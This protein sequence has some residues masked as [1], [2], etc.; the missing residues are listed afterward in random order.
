MQISV[1]IE[2]R[3]CIS[4]HQ[5]PCAIVGER[6]LRANVILVLDFND[7]CHV[8]SSRSVLGRSAKTRCACRRRSHLNLTPASYKFQCSQ[9]HASSVESF[10]ERRS[11]EHL[12]FRP[13]QL[14]L[15]SGRADEYCRR[16]VRPSAFPAARRSRHE[17]TAFK[18]QYKDRA[19]TSLEIHTEAYMN[20]KL[21]SML[22]SAVTHASEF[23]FI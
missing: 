14:R 13:L 5:H 17:N 18:R 11:A 15:R 6:R 2:D 12:C 9:V 10:F 21:S 22:T 4:A 19:L 1:T 7:I 16:R 8:V 23:Y 3:E 20:L